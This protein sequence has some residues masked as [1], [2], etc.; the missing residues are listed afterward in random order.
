MVPKGTDSSSIALE[1]SDLVQNGHSIMVKG[2]TES[3]ARVMVNGQEAVV[4][5][6]GTF[7]YFTGALPTGENMITV[8]AQNAKGGVNTKQQT[9]VIQ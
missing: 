4:K 9:V 8:T 1:L 3:G 2:R 6:D 7:I 5:S